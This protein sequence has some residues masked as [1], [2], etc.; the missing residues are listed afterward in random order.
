MP[1]RERG[2]GPR[3]PLGASTVEQL[4][5]ER[6]IRRSLAAQ[7]RIGASGVHLLAPVIGLRHK[8][9][10]WGPLPGP[11]LL[12]RHRPNPRL[13][14]FH[15]DRSF[16][17]APSLFQAP[18]MIYPMVRDLAA[19]GVD[20]AVACRVLE[21]SRSGFYDWLHRQ[22]R[23]SAGAAADAVLTGTIAE[24][25]DASRG[26]Y[27]SPRVHAELRLGRGV[28]CSRKR[29]ARPR[30]IQCG[31]HDDRVVLVHHAARA[32]R[33]PDLGFPAPARDGDLRM[34]RGVLQP[35]SA[36]TPPWTTCPRSTTNVSTR[37]PPPRHDH[38]THRV[39]ETG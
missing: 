3:R 4:R 27:G 28:A 25:H 33:P 2:V 6:A 29:V 30:R 35:P 31:Q 39:R 1:R 21:V 20:V 22:V 17:S 8:L 37:P 26:C 15:Q 16:G 10:R 18:K 14:G 32:A 24:I 23:P 34:D 5:P 38:H 12:H 11:A 13:L 7:H 36:A 19:D 9:K